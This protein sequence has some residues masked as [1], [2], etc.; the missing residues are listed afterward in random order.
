MRAARDADGLG[1]ALEQAE[2]FFAQMRRVEATR[3]RRRS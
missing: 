1:D 3:I 2:S